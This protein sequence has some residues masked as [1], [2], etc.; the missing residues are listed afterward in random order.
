MVGVKTVPAYQ[1]Y[2][3]IMAGPLRETRGSLGRE[4][5]ERLCAACVGMGRS[6]PSSETEAF[7]ELVGEVGRAKGLRSMCL[8]DSSRM[9]RGR[10]GASLVRLWH[11]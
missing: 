4:Q 11:F 2:Q 3:S 8:E 1:S 7:M 10:H 9:A 6:S 5:H